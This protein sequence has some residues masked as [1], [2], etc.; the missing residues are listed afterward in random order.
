MSFQRVIRVSNPSPYERSDLVEIGDLNALGV[1]LTL[2]ERSLRLI[3]HWPGGSTEEVAH[4]IDYPF[5]K[6]AGFRT[7]VFYSRNTPPGDP[8]YKRVSAEFSLEEGAPGFSAATAPEILDIEHYSA[9]G[10]QSNTWD[11]T[12]DV[13]GVGLSNGPDGLQV[14]FSLVPRP[15]PWSPHNY[16]GAATSIL[17]RR[18]ERMTG[19]GEALAPFDTGQYPPKRW[20]QLT[21][22]DFYPLPWE[23]RWYQAESMMGNGV[24][25]PRYTLVWSNTGPLRAT[26]TLK[27]KAIQV[28]YGGGPFFNEDKKEVTCYVYRIISMYPNREFYTEQLIARP[29]A[30]G[31]DPSRRISLA[32]RA[33]FYSYLGYHD[34]FP[35]LLARFEDVPDYFAIWKSFATQHRGA[36]FASDSHVRK[37]QLT[38]REVRWR[39]QLGH[40]YRCVHLFPFHCWP[41][42]EFSPFHEVGHTAWYERLLKP[43]QALPLDRYELP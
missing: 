43:L 42:G 36:A 34:D 13:K 22:V 12:Q 6:D 4:Q 33:H 1:P 8:D 26:V 25:E 23:R 29:E 10:S 19:A 17:H 2:N 18:A 30:A 7:L 39:L 41:E 28:R 27:S 24:D 32:F 40:E 16:A 20:G 38:P 31:L 5:G 3:R 37:L 21:R 11:R 35:H 9:P 15:E 14:Y